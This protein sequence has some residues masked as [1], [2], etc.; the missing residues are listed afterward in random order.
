MNN[1]LN[2]R[3]S[4]REIAL[5]LLLVVILLVGMYFYFVHY[6]ITQ[7]HAE[8]EEER[9]EIALSTEVAEARYAVYQSMKSELAEIFAMPEDKLTVMPEYD[10]IQTL[11]NYFHV[12]FVDGTNEALNYDS[13]SV[14]GN[15]AKRTVRFSFTA[16]S[17][18]QA[19]EILGQLAGTGY[20]CL[21][22]NVSLVPA[23]SGGEVETGALRVSGT[24]TFYELA[25]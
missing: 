5:I 6:P 17:Y 23:E 20:R 9:E 7:R 13:V 4:R 22:E 24:I 10:N 14:N 8:I 25:S 1:L 19:K 18:E 16:V 12:I 21:L 2:R 15:I 11:M 3:F